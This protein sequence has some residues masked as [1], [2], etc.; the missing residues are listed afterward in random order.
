M[1]YYTL[2]AT[3]SINAILCH[4]L[5]IACHVSVIIVFSSPT[6]K[7]NTAWMYHPVTYST[8]EQVKNVEKSYKQLFL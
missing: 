7:K 2:V 6:N 8:M 1:Q 5:P 4:C 3:V